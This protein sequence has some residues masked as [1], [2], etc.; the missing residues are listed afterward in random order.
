MQNIKKISLIVLVFIATM[1]ITGCGN[2]NVEGTLEDLMTKVYQDVPEDKRPM[3]L[4]NITLNDDNIEYYIGTKDVPYEDYD[5][6]E[7]K[8]K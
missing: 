8:V 1:M 3:M 4:E 2:K 5:I 6:I 7:F